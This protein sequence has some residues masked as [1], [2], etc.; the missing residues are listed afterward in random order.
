M[1][2]Q[3]IMTMQS[4]DS[5]SATR[6]SLSG[7]II[8]YD[9]DGTF[10]DTAEDLWRATNHVLVKAWRKPVPLEVVRGFVG[11]GARAMLE[12]GFAYADGAPL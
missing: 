8:I 5:R 4:G 2:A 7:S 9:L 3:T 10:I 11:H 12:Q 6:G 1:G